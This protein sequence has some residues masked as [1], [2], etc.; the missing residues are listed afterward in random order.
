MARVRACAVR[1]R[2]PCRGPEIMDCAI[3][4]GLWLKHMEKKSRPSLSTVRLAI[5]NDMLINA[6]I[7]ITNDYDYHIS[8]INTT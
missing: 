2:R 1:E 3:V 6:S 8:Y 5:I 4:I 7:S